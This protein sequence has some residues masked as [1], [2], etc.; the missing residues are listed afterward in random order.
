[1][2]ALTTP[3]PALGADTQAVLEVLRSQRATA[4]ASDGKAMDEATVASLAIGVTDFEKQQVVTIKDATSD[5]AQSIYISPDNAGLVSNM[6]RRAK[7]VA[8]WLE[9]RTKVLATD[10]AEKG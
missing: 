3:A 6:I 9:P 1:M 8:A 5:F 10:V 7:K 4:A 2:T